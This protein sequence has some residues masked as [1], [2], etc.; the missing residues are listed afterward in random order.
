MEVVAHSDDDLDSWEQ[1]V[2]ETDYP[3]CWACGRDEKPA[4]WYAQ[5]I[6]PQRAHLGAGSGSIYRRL[7]RKQACLLCPLCH[8]KHRSRPLQGM[9]S[10]SN[11]IW[12]KMIYDY[13]YYDEEYIAK[14]W[15]GSPPEPEAIPRSFT[16]EYISRRQQRPAPHSA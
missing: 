3:W 15:V 12:L 1:F 9:I 2:Y 14:Y 5:W 7:N 16:E 6:C 10:N 4:D 11:M 13:E 8:S